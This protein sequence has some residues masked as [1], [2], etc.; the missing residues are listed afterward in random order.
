MPKRGIQC[1]GT[2]NKPEA[3]N[4]EGEGSGQKS[5]TKAINISAVKWSCPAPRHA[6][7]KGERAYTSY[8]FLKMTAVWDIVPRNLLKQTGVSEVRN[9][10]IIRPWEPE[11][12]PTHSSRT[13]WGWVVSRPG[14]ALPPGVRDPRYPVD[15]RLGGPQ[16]WSGHRGYRKNPLP[17]FELLSSSL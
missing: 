1:R 11:T 14:R 2:S 8:S 5:V 3:W 9:A 13:K 15:R 17:R 10:S 6:D 7:G 4:R 16:G 12:S